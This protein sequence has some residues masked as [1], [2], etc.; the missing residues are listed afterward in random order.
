[1]GDLLISC[2]KRSLLPIAVAVSFQ[3]R[4]LTPPDSVDISSSHSL[5]SAATLP[6]WFGRSLLEVERPFLCHGRRRC[7]ARLLSEPKPHAPVFAHPGIQSLT[8]SCRRQEHLEDPASDWPSAIRDWFR[9]QGCQLSQPPCE[10]T[11]TATRSWATQRVANPVR[12]RRH[13]T[14]GAAVSAFRASGHGS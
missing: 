13:R 12:R 1:M 14:G 3:D 11:V 6:G 4:L 8:Q 9:I 5:A 10:R 7:L 2:E